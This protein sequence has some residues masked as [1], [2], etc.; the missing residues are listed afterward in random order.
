MKDAFFILVAEKQICFYYILNVA[1]S[2]HI[3]LYTSASRK[4]RQSNVPCWFI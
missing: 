3:F 2:E 4:Q 1:K